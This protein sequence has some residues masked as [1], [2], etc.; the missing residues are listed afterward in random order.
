[1]FLSILKSLGFK[2]TWTSLYFVL[3]H[4]LKKQEKIFAN[5]QLY[6]IQYI[7]YNYRKTS[8]FMGYLHLYC[9]ST[10]RV[11]L[12]SQVGHLTWVALSGT[13]PGSHTVKM[14]HSAMKEGTWVCLQN[15]HLAVSWIYPSPLFPVKI[16]TEKTVRIILLSFS[17]FVPQLFVN[18]YEEVSF[19]A[20]TYLTGGCNYR[21][22]VTDGWD[23]TSTQHPEVFGMHENVY[24]SKDLQQ[25]KLLFDS[26]ILTQGGGSKGGGSSD[27]GNFDN[28]SAHVKFPVCYTVLMQEML[29]YNNLRSTIRVSLQNLIKAIKGLVVMDAELEAIAGSLL[30]GKVFTHRQWGLKVSDKWYDMQKPHVFRFFFTQKY[31]IPIG[32]HGFNYEISSVLL[33]DTSDSSPEDGVYIHGLFLDGARWDRK[34]GVLAEQY[35]KVLFDAVPIIWIKPKPQSIYVC[36]LYKTSERKGTLSTTLSSA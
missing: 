10:S 35:P 27:P 25:T 31:S 21:G 12:V 5:L 6:N 15:C 11:V 20:I 14:I 8:T 9:L 3:W 16:L 4:A 33:S 28:E 32:L 18:E 22:R 2:T 30:L 19:E 23:L 34:S 29:R 1:M 24:I 36:P 17:L 26:L 13:R 7:I